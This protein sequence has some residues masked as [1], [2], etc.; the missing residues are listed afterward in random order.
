ML[1]FFKVWQQSYPNSIFL[2]VTPDEKTSILEVA[3]SVGIPENNLRI[4]QGRRDEMPL[5]ISLSNYSIFFIKEA[6]SKK[7][8]SP[9][10]QGEIMAMGVPAICNGEV[11]DTNYVVEKYRSGQIV[12]KFN[13]QA[14]RE[15]IIQLTNLA[16]DSVHIRQGA[17]EFYSLQEGVHQYAIVY[18]KILNAK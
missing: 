17:K 3:K 6:Y 14:Y 2:I 18:N 16:Y 13:E 5:Y 7:A 8:S 11:G 4:V 10:K 12:T 1:D 15:C 9:T